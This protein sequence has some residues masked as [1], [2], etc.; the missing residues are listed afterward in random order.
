MKFRKKLAAVDGAGNGRIRI[1]DV[2]KGQMP[3]TIEPTHQRDFTL[4]E[5]T[6]AI[7]KQSHFGHGRDMVPA[8]GQLDA[9]NPPISSLKK[10]AARQDAGPPHQLS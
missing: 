10:K 9:T 4:A 3:A 5:R 7:I 1:S 2:L 8:D 6:S